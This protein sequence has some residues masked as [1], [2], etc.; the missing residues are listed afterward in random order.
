MLGGVTE[1]KKYI[2][3]PRKMSKTSD[4][5]VIEGWLTKSPPTKRIWRAVSRHR[6]FFIVVFTSGFKSVNFAKKNAWEVHCFPAVCVIDCRKCTKFFTSKIVDYVFFL[7][8]LRKRKL[9]TPSNSFSLFEG[10]H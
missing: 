2:C 5:V 1:Y 8:F 7:V 4:E 3:F 6:R 10:V 9:M